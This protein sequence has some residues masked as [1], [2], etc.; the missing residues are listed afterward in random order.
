[1][2][3][4]FNTLVSSGI[5]IS[6]ISALVYLASYYYLKGFYSSYGIGTTLISVSFTTIMN[7]SFFYIVSFFMIVFIIF[8]I[9]KIIILFFDIHWIIS[10]PIIVLFI[11]MCFIITSFNYNLNLVFAYVFMG[12]IIISWVPLFIFLFRFKSEKI[13]SNKIRDFDNLFYKRKNY[14][15]KKIGFEKVSNQS[16]HVQSGNKHLLLKSNNIISVMFWVLLSLFLCVFLLGNIFYD[17]GKASAINKYKYS[18]STNYSNLIIVYQDPDKFILMP[19]DKATNSFIESYTIVNIENIGTIVPIDLK[20]PNL[21][22]LINHDFLEYG[23]T[24][25]IE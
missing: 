21:P 23:L 9:F 25:L 19:L 18:Y 13:W 14:V 2:K 20:N 4:F 16:N 3:K 22:K 10:M 8:L 17:M 5:V 15:L 7:I 6:I 11:C 12:I 1:M 24:K